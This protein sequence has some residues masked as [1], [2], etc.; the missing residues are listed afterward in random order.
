MRIKTLS[1]TLLAACSL[2]LA[3]PSLH[4]Q[5]KHKKH[6]DSGEPCT[7]KVTKESHVWVIATVNA[8]GK[9]TDTMIAK[10]SGDACMDQ[11]ALSM[12]H[13]HSFP[14]L[15]KNRMETFDHGRPQDRKFNLD[16]KVKPDAL[17]N[18]KSDGSASSNDE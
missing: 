7:A 14:P 1:L 10:S 5:K 9:I 12:A 2:M 15:D 16:L 11:K 18:A 6:G 3:V 4:A 13:D 8:K 17:Q